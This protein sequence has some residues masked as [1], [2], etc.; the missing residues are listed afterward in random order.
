MGDRD[1]PAHQKYTALGASGADSMSGIYSGLVYA[2]AMMEVG[3]FV[4]MIAT[5]VL[6]FLLSAQCQS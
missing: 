5:G 4:G 1:V 3:L 2:P 6:I